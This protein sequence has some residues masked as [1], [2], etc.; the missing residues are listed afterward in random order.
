MGDYIKIRQNHKWS[1]LAHE[2]QDDYVVFADAASKIKVSSGK[3]RMM[4]YSDNSLS[5]NQSYQP[6]F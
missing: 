2:L 1:R 3:V 4:F 5:S 6:F